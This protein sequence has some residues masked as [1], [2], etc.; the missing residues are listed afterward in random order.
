M[1]VLCVL[2]KFNRFQWTHWTHNNEGPDYIVEKNK[3]ITCLLISDPFIELHIWSGDAFSEVDP[4][5]T[6][7][8]FDSAL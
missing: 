1:K 6:A 8:N 7:E 2:P 3:D 4:D 5:P